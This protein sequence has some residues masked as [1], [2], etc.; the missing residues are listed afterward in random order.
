MASLFDKYII[1]D[2]AS[3]RPAFRKIFTN[4]FYKRKAGDVAKLMYK[5]IKDNKKSVVIINNELTA[6]KKGI[7][8]MKRKDILYKW[9]IS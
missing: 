7:R 5:I 8:D 2:K 9:E 1:Y 6:I 3:S 4:R